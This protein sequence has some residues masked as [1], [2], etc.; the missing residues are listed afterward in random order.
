MTNP[1]K[2]L[3]G[4]MIAAAIAGGII[5][6]DVPESEAQSSKTETFLQGNVAFTDGTI[7]P[8]GDGGYYFIVCGEAVA[9][10][11]RVDR[12]CTDP[13]T[14]RTA[15]QRT[16]AGNTADIMQR[17]LMRDIQLGDAGL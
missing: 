10:S 5:A 11:G 17:I 15:G 6:L 1:Q 3:T 13:F 14:P 9:N 4:A 2:L 16:I 8:A 12:H 7:R